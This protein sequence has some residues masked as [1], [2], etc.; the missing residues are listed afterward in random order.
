MPFPLVDGRTFE[1]NY[2]DILR[3][4]ALSSDFAPKIGGRTVKQNMTDLFKQVD[5]V[6][7][8]LFDDVQALKAWRASIDSGYT[9]TDPFAGKG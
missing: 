5:I 2:T 1:Q 8:Q 9:P 6:S 3:A 4:F 7:T